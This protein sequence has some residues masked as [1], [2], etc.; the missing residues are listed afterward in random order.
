MTRHILLTR[1][2]NKLHSVPRRLRDF[3]EAD[4]LIL[5]KKPHS[6]ADLENFSG[7]KKANLSRTL[8][9]LERYGVVVLKKEKN[10]IVPVVDII[11]FF[12]FSFFNE[13]QPGQPFTC[14][15]LTIRLIRVSIR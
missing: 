8:R 3:F 7:R 1:K 13:F 2:I 4:K 10:R 11:A 6:L 14:V 9:T 12:S 5:E 15:G